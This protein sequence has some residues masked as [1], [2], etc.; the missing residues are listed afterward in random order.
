MKRLFSDYIFLRL[1]HTCDASANASENAD[2]KNG[3]FI[4][5]LPLRLHFACV[6]RYNTTQVLVPYLYD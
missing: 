1:I 2:E 4:I 6:N 3:E 5:F